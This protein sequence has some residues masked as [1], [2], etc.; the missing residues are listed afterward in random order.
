MREEEKAMWVPSELHAG[1]R[2]VPPKAGNLTRRPRSI[3]HM[4]MSGPLL[5]NEAKAM[6]ELSGEMRGESEMESEMGDR[7]L[8]GAVIIH[9]PDFLMAAAGADEIELGFGDAVDSAA[10]PEDDLV[11]EAMGDQAGVVVRGGLAI[12]LGQHLRGLRIL[13]VVEPAL[14]LQGCRC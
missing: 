1:D 6:R 8:V 4:V 9:R 3:D 12:L 7:V 11:G 10:E 2:V 14:H 13:H 5:K